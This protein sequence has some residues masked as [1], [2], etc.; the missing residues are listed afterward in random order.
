MNHK[1]TLIILVVVHVISGLIIGYFAEEGEGMVLLTGYIGLFFCQTSLLGI[2]GGLATYKWPIRLFGVIFGIAYLVP[3]L[4]FS[5]NDW[6]ANVILLVILST[7]V[8][9]GVML[10]VRRFF[11]RLQRTSN[12]ALSVSA[13]GLQFSIR[14][15]MLLTLAISC[16]LAIGRLIQPHFQSGPQLA[17]VVV[18]GMCFVSVGL[19]SAWAMLG[20]RHVIL[21]GIVV[22][23]VSL[24]AALIPP[25]LWMGLSDLLRWTLM[26]TWEA[27]FL[28]VSLYV[29]RRCGYRLVR[30]SYEIEPSQVS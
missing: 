26:M 17:I 3:Q 13:E 10:I 21:R 5:L 28:L 7:I 4:C 6:D 27:S 24:V 11:A 25:L 14:H 23:V 1:L 30:L 8:V 19:M 22:L 2:W 16:T 18:V 29:V 12:A 20:T 9:A 15:L